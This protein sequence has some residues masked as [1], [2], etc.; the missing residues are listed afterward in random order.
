MGKPSFIIIGAERCGTTS[1]YHNICKHSKVY[2]AYQKE[3]EY[4]DRYYSNGV[5]WYE[6]QFDV[7]DGLIT[8]EATPTYVWNP[9][10]P[11]RVR[12]YNPDIKI[13]FL[14]RNYFDAIR[15]KHQQ[16]VSKGVETLS[17]ERALDCEAL[18][19]EGDLERVKYLPYNYYP[20][21]YSEYAYS[22]RYNYEKHLRNWRN[23][24]ILKIKSE[25]FF[26]NMDKTMQKVYPFLGLKF[27]RH[28]WEHLNKGVCVA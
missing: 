3:I 8:G 22:D 17:M 12:A 6:K 15:S 25:D 19:I 2:P 10:V 23:F 24:D 27:E 5:S 7:F 20:S 13:I 11:E 9:K 1:L 4:F 18:R 21:L 14:Y 26:L 28:M 16:Q